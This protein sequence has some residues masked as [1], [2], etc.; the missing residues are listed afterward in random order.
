MSLKSRSVGAALATAGLVASAVAVA[1]MAAA[2][3]PV[4]ACHWINGQYYQTYSCDEPADGV[5]TLDII[6]CWKLP[7]SDRSFARVKGDDGWAR[8][9]DVTVTV[10]ESKKCPEGYPYRTVVS[11][12]G[13]LLDEMVPTRVQLVMPRTSVAKR[14]KETY[15]A[16]LMPEGAIDWCPRR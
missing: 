6:D 7:V 11:I 1:P 15:V 16:C 2:E 14:M 8:S 5:D 4:A 3:G 12:P 9:S 13:T 10:R